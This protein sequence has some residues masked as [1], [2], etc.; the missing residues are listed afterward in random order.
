MKSVIFKTKNMNYSYKRMM[1]YCHVISKSGYS[2]L[3]IGMQY[4]SG[5]IFIDGGPI[6]MRA[7]PTMVAKAG[8]SGGYV[9]EKVFGNSAEYIHQIGLDGKTT[10]EHAVFNMAGTASRYNQAVR[11]SAHA[12]SLSNNEPFV[13]L[14]AEI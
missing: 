2:L 14:T 11:C 5:T 10:S 7:T 3:G 6:D 13:Y 9:Y 4:Y 12:F 1:V 8:S